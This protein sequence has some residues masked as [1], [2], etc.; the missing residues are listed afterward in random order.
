[1]NKF[2]LFS[3]ILMIAVAV[4]I[5]LMYIQPKVKEIRQAQ[6]LTTSYELET[7]NVSQ[8][9]ESLKAKIAAIE[10]INSSDVQALVNFMP[11]SVDEIAVMKDLSIILDRESITD[12]DLS[13]EGFAAESEQQESEEGVMAEA[14]K[15]VEHAFSLGFT[16]NYQQMKSLLGLLE[17]NNYLLQVSNLNVTA[18]EDGLL[19]IKMNISTFARKGM[20]PNQDV[21]E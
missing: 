19:T 4:A 6:D 2:S 20:V 7:S 17:T 18:A 5:I 8:V 12:Y 13:Y 15:V 3:Q 9:N 21:I 1:M 14:S 11:D 10:A 16:A